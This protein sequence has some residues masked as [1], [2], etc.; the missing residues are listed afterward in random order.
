MIEAKKHSVNNRDSGTTVVPIEKIKMGPHP[1]AKPCRHI[2]SVDRREAG[3]FHLVNEE[4]CAGSHAYG[5]GR[6]NQPEMG[7]IA[8]ASK[9][10]PWN[11]LG[12]FG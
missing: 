5:E 8:A 11:E 4:P 2:P 1:G 7:I 12:D 10:H 6:W 3:P 9:E